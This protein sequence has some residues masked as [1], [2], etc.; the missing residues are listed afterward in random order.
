[1]ARD[2]YAT[3]E[4]L[5]RR[6]GDT[7]TLPLTPRLPMVLTSD[8]EGVRQIFA[9]APGTFR[10][11]AAPT[12]EPVVGEHSL[13]LL[14]GRRHVRERQ[15]LAPA[16]HAV[17]VRSFADTIGDVVRRHLAAWRPGEVRSMNRL[18]ESISL[19][20]IVRVVFGTAEPE[21]LE[22]YRVAIERFLGAYST[23]LAVVPLLRHSIGPFGP[24]A[25]FVRARCDFLR[26]VDED[27]AAA[28]PLDGR[29]DVLATLLSA[30]DEDGNAMSADEVRDELV[31][32]VLAGHDTTTRALG[33]A[34]YFLHLAEGAP[35]LARLRAEPDGGYADAVCSEALRLNPVVNWVDRF[36]V[37]PF[38]LLEWSIPPDA[39]VAPCILLVHRRVELYPEPY[40]FRPERFLERKY[41]P[42][43]FLPFGGGAR[44]CIGQAFALFAMKIVLTEIGGRADL[45]ARGTVGRQAQTPRAIGWT[46]R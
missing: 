8:P 10:P 34:L 7:F 46:R 44:K 25:R 30:R 28:A 11:S 21:R 22:Q 19:E 14:D 17:R 26:L 6:Y 15:L 12:F 40:T 42:Y 1:M 37:Q 23:P 38:Q 9:A 29:A 24:W 16:L 41:A 31:T 35:V 18:L 27:V 5:Q 4:D 13:F 36:V 3:L 45:R 39:M 2:V 33:W 32:L 43:E 20:V